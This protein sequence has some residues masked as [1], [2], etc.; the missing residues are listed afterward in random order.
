[1]QKVEYL[2]GNGQSGIHFCWEKINQEGLSSYKR[3]ISGIKELFD[4]TFEEHQCYLEFSLP[5]LLPVRNF[6]HQVGHTFL[7]ENEPS[8]RLAHLLSSLASTN[9]PGQSQFN[10]FPNPDY[11][12][13]L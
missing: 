1:M 9:K 12:F 10:F 11:F 3:N 13:Y 6:K 4:F 5:T 7:S 8:Q 2:S